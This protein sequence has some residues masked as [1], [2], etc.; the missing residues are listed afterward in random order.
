MNDAPD[1]ILRRLYRQEK[2]LNKRKVIKGTRWWLLCNG[3]DIFDHEFKTGLDNA[4]KMNEPLT[5]AYYLKESLREIR[6]QARK[7]QAAEALDK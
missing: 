6:T 1:E 5:K 4:L 2:D 3:K 7:E